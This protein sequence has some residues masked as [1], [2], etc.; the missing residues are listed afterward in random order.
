M[1]KNWKTTLVGLAVAVGTQ[2]A[3][4]TNW[5]TILLSLAQA[6]AGALAA[7]AGAFQGK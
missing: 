5:K 2:F 3:V 4:G 7:D 6:G 1:I